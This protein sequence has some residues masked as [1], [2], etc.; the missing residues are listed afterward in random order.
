MSDILARIAPLYFTDPDG[1]G[2]VALR[3]YVRMNRISLAAMMGTSVSDRR[4]LVRDKLD[5]IRVPTLVLV[6]R[7]DFICSPMQA[8]IIHDGIRGSRLAVFEKSGHFPWIEEPE[9]FFSTVTNFL[10]GRS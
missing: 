2:V 9:L 10:K 7:H 6:G 1:E 8:R 3:E 5:T 4:F